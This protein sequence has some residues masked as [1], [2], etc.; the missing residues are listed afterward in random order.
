M[1]DNKTFHILTVIKALAA[2]E[3]ICVAWYADKLGVSPRTMQRYISDIAQFFGKGSVV[4]KTKGCY[5]A[6]NSALFEKVLIRKNSGF[7]SELFIDFFAERLLVEN[8]SPS[9]KK[10]VKRELDRNKKIYT[11]K[12]DLLSNLPLSILPELK[13]AIL[14]KKYINLEIGGK[15]QSLDYVKPIR[16]LLED[17]EIYLA[18]LLQ[19]Y[20][21]KK[22]VK[23]VK[24]SHITKL[25]VLDEGFTIPS[26]LAG[27]LDKLSLARL[28]NSEDFLVKIAFSPVLSSY[29]RIERPL[30]RQGQLRTREDGWSEVEF[31]SNNPNDVYALVKKHLPHIKI[32]SPEYLKSSFSKIIKEY[33]TQIEEDSDG[34]C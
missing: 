26:E 6:R 10:I 2:K 23:F 20:A 13:E 32:V 7:S 34:V 11:I 4:L 25:K 9:S 21:I 17:C 15:F 30:Y 8:L 24:L 22:T 29:F 19:D 16:L 5:T 18:Y 3:T 33:M 27:S 1:N 12:S 14:E 31:F 28:I